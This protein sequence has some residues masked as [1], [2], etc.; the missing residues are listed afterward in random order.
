MPID[1]IVML[2]LDKRQSL[3]PSIERSVEELFMTSVN[4]FVVGDGSKPDLQY[5]LLDNT[6]KSYLWSLLYSPAEHSYKG[7]ANAFLS[8]K[9]IFNRCIAEGLRNVLFLEDDIYFP[10]RF[11]RIFFSQEVQ[12]FIRSSSWDAIYLGWQAREYNSD[13]DNIERIESLWKDKSISSIERVIP[14]Y[15]SISGLH[16]ILLSKK[17]INMLAKLQ[18]GPMDTFL[19]QNM[20]WLKLYY[21]APK[22]VGSLPSYSWCEQKWQDRNPLK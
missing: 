17:L 6:D 12:N 20:D 15:A 19:Q 3:W 16:A 9:A 14:M 5:D 22:V 1:K 7:H 18:K 2:S 11:T 21:I 10:S 4:K 13:T 8:H